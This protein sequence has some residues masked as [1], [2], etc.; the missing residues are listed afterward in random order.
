MADQHESSSH[1][2]HVCSERVTREP[3]PLPPCRKSR[4]RSTM[5]VLLSDADGSGWRCLSVSQIECRDDEHVEQRGRG[6]AAEDHD[7]HRCLDLAARP[8]VVA[9]AAEREQKQRRDD[10]ERS[11]GAA[12]WPSC[13]LTGPITQCV[14]TNAKQHTLGYGRGGRGSPHAAVITRW[15]ISSHQRWSASSRHDRSRHRSDVRL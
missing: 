15:I 6:Q 12:D 7:R 13:R 4:H 1:D 2:D 5:R 10:S 9:T 11:V 3:E 8:A 14:N